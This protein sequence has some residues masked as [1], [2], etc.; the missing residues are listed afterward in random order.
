M[1][2]IWRLIDSG[3]SAASF[4]MALDE[5]LALSVRKGDS[6][7][8]LRLYE[9]DGP[10]VSLGRFQK[11]SDIDIEYCRSRTIPVVRR[12]TG[13]R[14]IL[15]DAELTY[16]FSVKTDRQP[17]SKGLLDSYKRISSAFT[18]AFQRSG[19]KAEAREQREK[20]TVLSGGPLCFQSSSYGEI[21]IDNK[22][23]AGAAQKRWPDGLLQQGSVPYHYNEDM[24]R[25]IFRISRDIDLNRCMTGIKV[26]MP[27]L[28][29]ETFKDTLVRAFEDI[30]SISFECSR[31]SEEELALAL[32]LQEEKYLQDS[33]NLHLS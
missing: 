22:K 27:D 18:L 29:E 20:G 5:T 1:N 2:N 17:F 14:A 19:F 10:S 24:M 33:W 32:R 13:G 28:A 12:P 26:V 16:S 15:H 30:F 8:V 6:P 4:N 21:L 31:P 23:I 3:R 9:W 11:I 25:R 7:P